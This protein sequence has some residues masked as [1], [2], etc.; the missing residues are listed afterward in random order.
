MK[1]IEKIIEAYQHIDWTQEKVALG[2][3]VKVEGSA[4]RRIGARMFVSNNGQWVG[5]ISGG[6]LEGDALKRAKIAIMKNKSSIV[7]Y[8]T[9]EDDPHQIGVGLGCNGR[10]EVLFTPI[11]HTNKDNQIEFL[12]NIPQKRIATI[13]LQI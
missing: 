10:I 3:V 1:E 11:N 5:G 6:C 4:Y 9:S 2:T 8:D 13:L 12:K 7:V